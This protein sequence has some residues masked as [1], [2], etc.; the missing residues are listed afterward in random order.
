M[1]KKIKNPYSFLTLI[2]IIYLMSMLIFLRTMQLIDP[3]FEAYEMAYNYINNG[4]VAYIRISEN[5]YV[6]INKLFGYFDFSVI[7]ML[8]FLSLLSLGIKF[9][10][11]YYLNSSSFVVYSFVLL[12]L[13]SYFLIHEM[14]QIRIALAISFYYIYVIRCVKKNESNQFLFFLILA[15]ISFN[16]HKS[17][18]L[19][20]L[21]SF[22]LLYFK[23]N[24]FF[25]LLLI[26]LFFI[27]FNVGLLDIALS[28]IDDYVIQQ[29]I[30]QVRHIRFVN[31]SVLNA[32]SILSLLTLLIFL[33]CHNNLKLSDNERVL[34]I[35]NIKLLIISIIVFYMLFSAQV[36]AYRL[37]EMLRSLVP[38]IS[39]IYL[40]KCITKKSYILI[41]FLLFSM[42]FMFGYMYINALVK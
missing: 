22:F 29:Y 27:P 39:V 35:L 17:S 1:R 38:L 11:V 12:Y 2:P 9:Y 28:M 4:K 40:S 24:R 7:T 33:Y 34:S 16:F 36:V 31:D 42:N 26:I 15:L 37:S 19:L 6:W 5:I 14:I 32:T 30:Y 18:I 41:T 13:F 8:W 3:D 23:S 20:F 10:S 25:F 21:F